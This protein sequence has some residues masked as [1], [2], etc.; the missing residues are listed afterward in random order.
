MV[1]YYIK[2]ALLVINYSLLCHYSREILSFRS[3]AQHLIYLLNLGHLVYHLHVLICKNDLR[4][5]SGVCSGP[6]FIFH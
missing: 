2:A 1:L 3:S 6:S 4:G 5:T